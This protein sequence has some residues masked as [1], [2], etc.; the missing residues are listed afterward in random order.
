MGF[1]SPQGIPEH[2][3]FTLQGLGTLYGARIGFAYK[4]F[5]LSFGLAVANWYTG[6]EWGLTEDNNLPVNGML[7]RTSATIGW[8]LWGGWVTLETGVS[9]DYLSMWRQET[10]SS[11]VLFPFHVGVTVRL[12]PVKMGR[13]TR[14]I[15]LR[16]MTSMAFDTESEGSFINASFNLV[17]QA[18]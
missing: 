11:L 2:T 14:Y 4:A 6:E 18:F 3:P 17:F 1:L 8:R 16:A 7:T 9:V 5:Q 12:I 13:N 10:H 15:S